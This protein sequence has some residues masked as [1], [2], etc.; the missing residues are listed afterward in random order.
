M[1]DTWLFPY[2]LL[3]RRV[4]VGPCAII[5]RR[6]FGE[7]DA[8]TPRVAAVVRGLLEMYRLPRADNLVRDAYGCIV[9]PKE[10]KARA[11]TR[12]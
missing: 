10:G 9:V 8:T 5:P 1:A 7:V 11:V 3:S 2:L 6:D 4:T 12:S